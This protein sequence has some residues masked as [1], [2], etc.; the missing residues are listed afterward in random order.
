[1]AN[2]RLGSYSSVIVFLVM[3]RK[4]TVELLW[5]KHVRAVYAPSKKSH[6][7]DTWHLPGSGCIDASSV[8]FLSIAR[9]LYTSGNIMVG[10]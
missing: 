7:P 2:Q 5:S 3:R 8:M 6:S 1:M 10:W 4:I 9:V